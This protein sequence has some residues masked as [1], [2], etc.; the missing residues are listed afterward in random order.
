MRSLQEIEKEKFISIMHHL[1]NCVH[2][3]MKNFIFMLIHKKFSL[4]MIQT[5]N[6]IRYEETLELEIYL[7]T[8]KEVHGC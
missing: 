6:V 2:I 4:M 3:A 7:S 5:N 8:S 1:T